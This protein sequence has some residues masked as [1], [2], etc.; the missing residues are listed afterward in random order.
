[1]KRY[2]VASAT[3]GKRSYGLTVGLPTLKAPTPRSAQAHKGSHGPPRPRATS[4]DF[5]VRPA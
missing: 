4:H 1:M 5:E 3:P 2:Y